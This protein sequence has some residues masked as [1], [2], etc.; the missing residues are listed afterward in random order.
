MILPWKKSCDHLDSILKSRDITFPTSLSSQGYGFAYKVLEFKEYKESWA[1]KNRCFW[2]VVFEKTLESPLDCRE[3]QPVH[4]KGNQSWI[5]IGS[6]DAEAE[7]QYFSHLMWRTD[8]LEKTLMLGKIGGGRRREQQRISW[9]DGITDSMDFSLSKLWKLVIN[10]ETWC[11]AVYWSG[12]VVQYWTTKLNWTTNY[13]K[14]I[15]F[16]QSI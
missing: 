7:N 16:L 14:Q 11:P 12:K 13:R 1:P 6:T 4:P 8:S 3:I 5:C 10:R 15:I 2:T 9:L